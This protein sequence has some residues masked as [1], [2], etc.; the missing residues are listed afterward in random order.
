MASRVPPPSLIR[1]TESPILSSVGAPDWS[2]PLASNTT[3]KNPTKRAASSVKILGVTVGQPSGLN[4][5]VLASGMDGCSTPERRDTSVVA[6][7]PSGIT[8]QTVAQR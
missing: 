2:L 1:T 4:F 7:S 8:P 6:V 3:F 5:H